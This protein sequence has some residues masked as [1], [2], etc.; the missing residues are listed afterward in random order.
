[1]FEV[2]LEAQREHLAILGRQLPAGGG[3]AQ[4]RLDQPV[5]LLPPTDDVIPRAASS[6]ISRAIGWSSEAIPR[7]GRPAR[8]PADRPDSS[9]GRET[10]TGTAQIINVFESRADADACERDRL[11]PVFEAAGL[12]E[13]I[14]SGPRPVVAEAF[15]FEHLA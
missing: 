15:E 12:T 5:A 13:R 4:C 10:A 3:Q 9:H 8:R 7:E 11:V 14:T 6:P 1:L 2:R